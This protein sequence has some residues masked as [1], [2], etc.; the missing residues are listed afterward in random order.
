MTKEQVMQDA[1]IRV[2]EVKSKFDD[3]GKDIESM[4]R[5]DDDNHAYIMLYVDHGIPEIFHNGSHVSLLGLVQLYQKV[6]DKN[7]LNPQPVIQEDKVKEVLKI[8]QKVMD[9][10]GE[11]DIDKLVRESLKK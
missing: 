1:R 4:H 2:D 7:V 5:E 3:I 8:I 10:D 11:D 9:E 6:L